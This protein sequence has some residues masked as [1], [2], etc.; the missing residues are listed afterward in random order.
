MR[1]VKL[2]FKNTCDFVVLTITQAELE[3]T[4]GSGK[5]KLA[6]SCASRVCP[7]FHILAFAT[8][9]QVESAAVQGQVAYPAFS[10]SL[11]FA[12]QRFQ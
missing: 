8:V 3:G 2:T 9:W 10:A 4:T 6:S 5:V 12:T 1:V 11:A 7:Y